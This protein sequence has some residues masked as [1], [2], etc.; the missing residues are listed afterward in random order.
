MEKRCPA[1]TV[2]MSVYNGQRYLHESIDS[3]LGQSYDDF[4][5]VIVNDGSTDAT[6][7]IL[8]QYADRDR[9]IVLLQ[10]EDKV[11]LSKSLN[12][13]LAIAQGVYIARQDADD[14]SLDERLQRQ[15]AFM[16]AH[17]QV[18]LLGTA[19]GVVNQGG[20]KVT[21]CQHPLGDT[22]IRWQLLFHNAFCHTSVLFRRQLVMNVE[23]YNEQ[24]PYS[25]DY[26]LWVRLMNVTIGANLPEPLVNWRHH[27]A[28]VGMTHGEE[29]QRIAAQIAYDQ[30][31][32]LLELPALEM[33]DVDRLRR[34]Y[35]HLPE[36][37]SLADIRI[38]R[39][40]VDMLDRFEGR[41]DVD[42]GCANS[43]RRGW[44]SRL[45]GRL[46]FADL[47]YSECRTL[48]YSLMQRDKRLTTMAFLQGLHRS[49]RAKIDGYLTR[50][51]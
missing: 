2:L 9:R 43:L 12:E 15:V 27:K 44:L 5:F 3:I 30:M 16:E 17:P 25:Q 42:K 26:D 41:K 46:S 10:H 49:C 29:Q 38:C 4:E 32:S 47:Q 31:R 23:S 13:G 24:C 40:L 14:V 51:A 37:F 19:Y 28:G 48:L 7:N 22:E 8:R 21:S 36:R 35:Y 6:E 20:G 11:G 33:A 1:V 18:G 34:W 39:I 45:G 50:A